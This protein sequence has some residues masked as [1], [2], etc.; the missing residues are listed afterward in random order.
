VALQLRRYYLRQLSQAFVG[1]S[2]PQG[3]IFTKD[4]FSSSSLFF[5]CFD[6]EGLFVVISR[7]S[8]D[9]V[10]WGGGD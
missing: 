10:A 5:A 6:M 2:F 8:F 3:F 9:Y 1:I 7:L 4:V